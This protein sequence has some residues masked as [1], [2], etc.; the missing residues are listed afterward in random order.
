MGGAE[1]WLYDPALIGAPGAGGARPT[2]VV[3][4][5]GPTGGKASTVL[6]D[7]TDASV[8]LALNARREGTDRTVCDLNGVEDTREFDLDDVNVYACNDYSALG[9]KA[10]TRREGGAASTVAEVNRAYEERFG[11]IYIVFASGKTADEMLAIA[12][13]R[14]TNSRDEEVA[15]AAAEQRKI[16][17][18]RLRR[19]TCQEAG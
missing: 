4:I 14:L 3:E 18:R 19:M 5:L 8:A 9:A 1:L 2:W 15:N 6:V 10:T 11:F 13:K 7:A 17:M 16:T 12:E